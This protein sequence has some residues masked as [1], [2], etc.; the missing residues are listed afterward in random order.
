MTKGVYGPYRHAAAGVPFPNDI[1]RQ[2]FGRIICVTAWAPRQSFANRGNAC[3]TPEIATV[4][5]KSAIVILASRVLAAAMKRP[6]RGKLSE[7]STDSS[8][9][10]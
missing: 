4:T 5:A 6:L 3:F 1:A 10:L 9:L 7:R 8:L 2:S